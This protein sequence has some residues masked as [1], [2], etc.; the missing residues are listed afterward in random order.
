M[1]D[2]PL[3]YSVRQEQHLD[4]V[5]SQDRGAMYDFALRYIRPEDRVLDVG[6]GDGAFAER[7]GAGETYLLDG[8]PATCEQLR[9]RFPNVTHATLPDLPFP[10]QFFD[11]IHC[12]HVIEHLAPEL[13]YQLLS[14]MD[15]CLCVDGYLV[16]SY[17]VFWHGFYNDLSHVRPYSESAILRYLVHRPGDA[18]R[19]RPV[20]SSGFELVDKLNRYAHRPEQVLICK[21]TG[22]VARLLRTVLNGISRGLSALGFRRVY[23]T[24]E[25]LVLKKDAACRTAL[26]STEP[27]P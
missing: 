20:V 6:C 24:G 2:N 23:V 19:T 10:D 11:V 13:V 14:Q 12:S 22:L 4:G 9:K 5:L 1:N 15:R 18:N 17:P 21:S 7:R 27:K 26:E 3:I 8:N 16:L 25:T